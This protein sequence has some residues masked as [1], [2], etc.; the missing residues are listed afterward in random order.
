MLNIMLMSLR[1]MPLLNGTENNL[2]LLLEY[3]FKTD[4][5]FAPLGMVTVL[6]EYIDRLII[7]LKIWPIMLSLCLM[8]LVAYY[9]FNYAGI[10]DLGIQNTATNLNLL[11]AIGGKFGKSK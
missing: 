4:T 1:N 5:V 6:L 10:I 11:I 9:A 3:I 2:I 8:L 7:F